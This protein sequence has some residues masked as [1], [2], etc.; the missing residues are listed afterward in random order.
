MSL[1]AERTRLESELQRLQDAR[2]EAARELIESGAADAQE[3]WAL[4]GYTRS[5]ERRI[6]QERGRLAACEQQIRQQRDTVTEA[7]RQYKL[8][9][10]LRERRW[11]E[12]LREADRE[13]SAAAGEA[14]LTR[15]LRA[16]K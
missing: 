13:A 16:P 12:W 6:A 15:W 10:N 11:Q 2:P 8:L 9:E 5:L 1:L 3:C 7:R 4:A 14:A